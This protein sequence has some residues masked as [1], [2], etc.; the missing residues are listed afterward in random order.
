VTSPPQG[1]HG[2]PAQ[3]AN[4]LLW[5]PP[6]HPG[7]DPSS[8]VHTLTNL[9]TQIVRTVRCA[10]HIVQLARGRVGA[11]YTGGPWEGRRGGRAESGAEPGAWGCTGE[12]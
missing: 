5:K 2:S 9:N 3:G 10:V 11:R 8:L 12:P 6:P 7:A 4:T 1:T